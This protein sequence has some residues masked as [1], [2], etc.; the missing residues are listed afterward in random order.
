MKSVRSADAPAEDL[1]HRLLTLP[2][3]GKR[4]VLLL[5]DTVL[6]AAALW[7]AVSLRLGLAA[8]I[9]A[10]W[11]IAFAIAWAVCIPV[12]AWMG[13][14]RAITRF[15]GLR[16]ALG[17]LAG[18]GSAALALVGYGL[19]AGSSLVP[20]SAA[21]IFVALTILAIGGSRLVM[22]EIASAPLSVAPRVIIY[23]A[24]EA[25]ARLATALRSAAKFRPVA[26]VDD[27]PALRGQIMHGL[28]VRRPDDLPALVRSAGVTQIFLALPS[29]SIGARRRVL[30][31]LEELAVRVQTVP[32]INE[33][34][35]GAARVE[36][37]REVD[38]ADLLGRDAV[39]PNQ[40]LL[41]ATIRGKTVLVTGAGGSIG[42]ELCRQIIRQ[43]PRRLLLLEM[44]ELA[45]YEIERELRKLVEAESLHVEI[46]P[47][48]GNAHHKFRVKEIFQTFGVQTV[49][50][51]AAYKHV[52]IVEQNIVEGL[53]NNIFSTWFTAEVALECKIDTFVL[54][55]TDKA[56]NPTNVMGATKRF[57]EMVLQGLQE[58]STHTRFCMV[59][60]GNVLESS[61]SVVP[62]FREQIRRGGPVTVTHPDVIRYFMTIPEAAQLVIQAGSMAVGG[63]VFVLDMGKPIKIDDLA[64]RMIQLSGLEIRDEEHP[65]GDIEI[66]YTGLRAA[67][68]LFEELLI[69][70]NVTGTQHPMIMRAVEHALPWERTAQYLAELMT[71]ARKFDCE[72]AL[73][74]LAEAVA[75]YRPAQSVVDL[76]WN[77]A[78]RSGPLPESAS[79]TDLASARRRQTDINPRS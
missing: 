61:G 74:I 48:L 52:P 35:S 55:S 17:V 9:G 53:H 13:L 56:V 71:C 40:G 73:G 5:V 46:V 23:G 12:F 6:L 14:Y 11:L 65:D 33:I 75:E 2:R 16:A 39:P 7:L 67:E 24:G 36:D 66:R 47:L 26:F 21:L 69:G 79:V 34:L 30:E 58:R 70:K 1:K 37:V 18:A 27:N 38:V 78:G 8:P 59:R 10:P 77:R 60:F 29:V 3:S 4:V 15:I 62:L 76:V 20:I 25:G 44:S 49:Y 28:K 57:A 51:A 54:I 68:K 64:R 32:D 50:H 43:A 22:R 42:S 45:L 72:A 31:R 41:D 19:L 63:D